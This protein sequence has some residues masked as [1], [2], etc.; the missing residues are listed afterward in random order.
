MATGA[1][2]VY[3]LPTDCSGL[4]TDPII[5]TDLRV[6]RLERKTVEWILDRNY[7]NDSGTGIP[8]YYAVRAKD[9]SGTTGTRYEMIVSPWPDVS[10][11]AVVNYRPELALLSTDGEYPMGGGAHSLTILQAALM[12]YE[13]R[14][15]ETGGVQRMLFYGNPQQGHEGYLARSIRIDSENT[16]GI[17]G[18]TPDPTESPLRHP[19]G[20]YPMGTYTDA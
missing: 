13:E 10:Y 6:G 17:L 1:S 3:A 8:R 18:C 11:T 20:P 5:S 19:L 9:H 12:L 15:G 7:R 16:S 2:G 4:L 14:K